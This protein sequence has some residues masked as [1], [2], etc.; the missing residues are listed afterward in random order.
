MENQIRYLG[1]QESDGDFSTADEDDETVLI[2]FDNVQ[3]IT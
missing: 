1:K 2:D 3:E